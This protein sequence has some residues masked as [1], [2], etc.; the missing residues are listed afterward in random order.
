MYNQ[1]KLNLIFW[2][3][4]IRTV[5]LN[6]HVYSNALNMCLVQVPLNDF[7]VHL[8]KKSQLIKLQCIYPSKI[9]KM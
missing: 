4:S 9:G 1:Q 3:N 5:S 7:I 6:T 2:G 8:T